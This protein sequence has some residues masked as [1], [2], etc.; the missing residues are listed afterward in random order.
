MGKIAQSIDCTDCD[1]TGYS[2]FYTLITVQVF[3]TP[4]AY[5]RYSATEGGLARFGEGQIKLDDRYLDI[6]DAS[7][8]VTV[9]GADW[10]FQRMHIPGQSFG[11]K[12]IILALTRR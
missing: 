2:N 7:R 10:N 3:Y 1:R 9:E 12:R 5:V 6:V 8:Y 11:Q 4:R